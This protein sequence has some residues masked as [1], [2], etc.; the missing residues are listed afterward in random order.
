ML[1]GIVSWIIFAEPLGFGLS[2]DWVSALGTCVIGYGAW[3]YARATHFH[4]LDRADAERQEV[5]QKRIDAM[6]L[7]TLRIL[8]LH[9]ARMKIEPLRTAQMC[10]VAYR[11]IGFAKRDFEQISWSDGEI[12]TF[13]GEAMLKFHWIREKANSCAARCEVLQ[14]AFPETEQLIDADRRK[15]LDDFESTTKELSDQV[16]MLNELI[17][18][19]ILKLRGELSSVETRRGNR[20]R[21]FDFNP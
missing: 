11:I 12:T 2:S 21:V 4:T 9:S 6:G 5:I 8:A 15:V 14:G 13:S 1:G 10:A 16:D 17:V 18:A 20:K 3:K 19:E 7:F